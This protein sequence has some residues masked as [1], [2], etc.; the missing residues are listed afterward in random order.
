MD[1]DESLRRYGLYPVGVDLE[2]VRSL[3]TA[4]ARLE[5]CAQGDGDTELMR[6]CCVQ[7]FNAGSPDDVLLIWQAK[8][9]SMD[10]D[11]S[12]GIQLPCGGGL[13]RTKAYLSEQRSPEA[14]AALRRLNLCE[15]AGDFE[16]FS[17]EVHAAYYAP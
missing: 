6:L 14:D 15:A 4:R 17:V 12:I 7:L 11:C 1:E 13:P 5:K 16:G 10:A 8:T 2:E 3:L 9:A